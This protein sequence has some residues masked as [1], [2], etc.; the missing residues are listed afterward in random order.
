MHADHEHSTCVGLAG[1]RHAAAPPR[2]DGRG[3]L[4][5][6][7]SM[8]LACLDMR[9]SP[10]ATEALATAMSMTVE[11]DTSIEGTAS[12]CAFMLDIKQE[13]CRGGCDTNSYAERDDLLTTLNEEDTDCSCAWCPECFDRVRPWAGE[14]CKGCE[15]HLGGCR[16]VLEWQAERNG[17]AH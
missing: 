8:A 2:L 4:D 17:G 1:R 10:R 13:H 14:R 9:I 16:L 5:A 15:N 3:E 11:Y 12:F 7:R 6:V